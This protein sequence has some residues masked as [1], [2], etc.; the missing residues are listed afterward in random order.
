[1]RQRPTDITLPGAVDLAALAAKR[2]AEAAAAERAARGEPLP[3]HVVEATEATF[4]AEVV[5]RS[6]QVPVVL[7]F[8][9]SWCG[10]C[11]QLSPVLEKLAAE[12]D[13]RWVLAKV[14]CDANPRLVQAFGVQ[15][16]PAVKLVLLGQPIP[17]F[18]F[19]GA[20]PEPQVR[21]YVTA[22]LALADQLR[23]R[24]QL[25]GAADSA[26]GGEGAPAE[27]PRLTPAYDAMDQGDW[28]GAERAFDA[29]L[30]EAPADAAAKAGRAMARLL[31]R[32]SVAD[33]EQ[34]LRAAQSAPDDV[35]AQALAADVELA[36]GLVEPALQR[37][38]GVVRRTAGDEREAARQ[39]LLELLEV[40]DPQDPRA[41]AAR[42]DLAA[43]L[44]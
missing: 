9:A 2:Q 35:A 11:T 19:S 16:I 37:L 8:W 20:L 41:L 24:G 4:A 22:V 44:F 15:G 43:A 26:A 17:D 1:M 31:G 25:G 34:V 6:M 23:E 21:Q 14:D 18:E 10:P 7:D 5:E 12:G 28:V 3:A 27:D 30:A 33:P 40:L 13:G 38:V 39:H 29:V 42:R 36:G 32:A